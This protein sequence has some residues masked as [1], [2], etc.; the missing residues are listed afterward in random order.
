MRVLVWYDLSVKVFEEIFPLL[1]YCTSF[2]VSIGKPLEVNIHIAWNDY[3][4]AYDK[5][6]MTDD[7]KDIDEYALF[8]KMWE[9][10]RKNAF[11]EPKYFPIVIESFYEH[12]MSKDPSTLRCI[13]GTNK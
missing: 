1:K 8:V 5:K 13:I 4:D 6:L 9:D 10:K 2:S 3:I 11:P 12:K 7:I